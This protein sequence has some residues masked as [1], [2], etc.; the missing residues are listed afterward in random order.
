MIALHTSLRRLLP[1]LALLVASACASSSDY[2]DMSAEELFQLG[3]RA[4]QEEEWDRA[5]ESL[6]RLLASHPGFQQ[7]TEARLLLGDALFGRE[8]YVSAAAEYARLI[9]R[10]P[11]S[12]EARSAGLG[13]CRAYAALSPIPQRDQSYTEQAA[14][15]CRNVTTDFPGTAEAERAREIRD[16]MLEKLAEKIYLNAEFYRRRDFH[17]SAILYYEDVVENYPDTAFAPPALLRLVRIYEELGY[18]EERD[19]ARDTL[20]ERYPDSL[21]AREVS[22]EG[23]GGEES[24]G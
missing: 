16:Q 6:E 20:L 8:E 22:G 4:V 14:T 2:Q 5:V 3:E 17:D 12:V 9:D 24:A 19:E 13:I 23:E 15:A 1:A 18:A 21:Q 10:Y 11:S 7:R